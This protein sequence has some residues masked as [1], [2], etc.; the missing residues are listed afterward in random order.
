MDRALR[1]RRGLNPRLVWL[2][3]LLALLVVMAAF[4]LLAGVGTYH[5]PRFGASANGSIVFVDGGSLE[6][7]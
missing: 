6:D 5:A 2:L 3:A 1:E 7:R 4:A